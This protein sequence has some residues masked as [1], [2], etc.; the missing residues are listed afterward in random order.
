MLAQ[1][2]I[3]WYVLHQV[4]GSVCPFRQHGG[5]HTETAESLLLRLQQ[6]VDTML[7]ADGVHGGGAV[8]IHPNQMRDKLKIFDRL[9][10]SRLIHAH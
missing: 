5:N 4:Q 9:R 1:P 2:E 8:L 3:C 6:M 7:I 10:L